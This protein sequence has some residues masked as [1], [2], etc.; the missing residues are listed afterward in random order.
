MTRRELQIIEGTAREV[1]TLPSITDGEKTVSGLLDRT[2]SLL[3]TAE[4]KSSKETVRLFKAARNELSDLRVVGVGVRALAM[5]QVNIAEKTTL[6]II[7]VLQQEIRPLAV[8][9]SSAREGVRLSLMLHLAALPA[10]VQPRAVDR[11]IIKRMQSCAQKMKVAKKESGFSREATD[12]IRDSG[13]IQGY[14]H[15]LELIELTGAQLPEDVATGIQKQCEAVSALVKLVAYI[16][17]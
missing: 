12:L 2:K 7:D 3:T 1:Q 6:T 8:I 13:A 4:S 9:Q 14:R 11:R 15:S 17:F 10:D 16:N 5:E